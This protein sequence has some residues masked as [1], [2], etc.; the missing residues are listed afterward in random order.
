MTGA[1]R[2]STTGF[3]TFMKKNFKLLQFIGPPV[4]PENQ[5]IQFIKDRLI[6]IAIWYSRAA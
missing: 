5:V 4:R 1:C 3:G 6:D 2:F